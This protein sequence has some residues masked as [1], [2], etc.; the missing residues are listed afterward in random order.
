MDFNWYIVGRNSGYFN[1][2]CNLVK[3]NEQYQTAEEDANINALIISL[4]LML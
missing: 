4:L 2:I 1:S 3:I